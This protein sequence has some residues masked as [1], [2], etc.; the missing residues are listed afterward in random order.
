DHY[1]VL[2]PLACLFYCLDSL[3]YDSKSRPMFQFWVTLRRS[4]PLWG[5]DG[6]RSG[7]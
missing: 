7:A 4:C 2:G 3:R 5:W 1:H 6:F